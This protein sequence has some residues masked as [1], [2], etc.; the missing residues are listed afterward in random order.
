MAMIFTCTVCREPSRFEGRN[1]AIAGG[2]VFVTIESVARLKYFILCP[3]HA[4]PD[5]LK[6][7]LGDQA[8][9]EPKEKK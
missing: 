3:A 9:K 4:G 8:P 6:K 5:W 1:A 2:W 7:A